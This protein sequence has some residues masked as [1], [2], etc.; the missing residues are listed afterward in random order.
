MT[1]SDNRGRYKSI[2]DRRPAHEKGTKEECRGMDIKICIHTQNGN[3]YR[4]GMNFAKSAHGKQSVLV[5]ASGS[6][7]WNLSRGVWEGR[8]A[9]D[10]IAGHNR[11]AA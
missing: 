8:D 7:E 1:R 3:I 4:C 6:S 9:H 10:V 11:R 5:F 2:P